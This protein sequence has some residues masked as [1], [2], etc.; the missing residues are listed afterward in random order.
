MVK[1]RKISKSK[2]ILAGVL[3]LLLFS[4]GI[5]LGMFI[6]NER[7]IWL[8]QQTDQQELDFKSIQFQY[9]YL[10][11]L[12][13]PEESCTVLQTTLKEAVVELSESLSNYQKFKEKTQINADQ[14]RSVGRRYV[15]DNVNYW[16]LAQKSKTACGLDVV[17]VLYFYHDDCDTCPNQG[18]IL[19]YFKNVFGDKFLVFPID[20]ELASDEP[21]IEILLNKFNVTAYPTIIIEN[22]KFE[23][24]VSPKQL[25]D[26]VCS[27]FK[28]ESTC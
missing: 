1:H 16:T 18:V 25:K 11:T 4:L 20:A 28:N 9:L 19:T 5:I 26:V 12:E 15:L 10:T 17:N 24:V 27:E 21:V 13:D 6:D 23:G 3:T 2:Y 22:E 8:E 14:Y 7:L